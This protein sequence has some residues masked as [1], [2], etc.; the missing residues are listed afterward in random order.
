MTTTERT[1]MGASIF[2]AGFSL[3]C[4]SL[5]AIADGPVTTIPVEKKQA[6]TAS[7]V[8]SHQLVQRMGPVLRLRLS[9]GRITELVDVNLDPKESNVG[10]VV[11]YE[12]VRYFE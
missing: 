6:A 10:Q 8:I 7:Q 5:T 1:F 4:V 2:P 3:L 9:N 11:K 12:F